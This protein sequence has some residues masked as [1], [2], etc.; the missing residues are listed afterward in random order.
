MKT[1]LLLLLA[2]CASAPQKQIA[3]DAITTLPTVLVDEAP[4]F[5]AK[6]SLKWPHE[7][8]RVASCVVRHPGFLAEVAAHP[9]Y[10]YTDKTPMEVAES[11]RTMHPVL[12]RT[13]KTANPWSKAIA[14]RA[15]KEPQSIYFN[16]RK[17]PRDMA[18]NA[19]TSTHEALHCLGFGHGDNDIT[20][21]T[22]QKKL[23]APYG[24]GAIAEKYVKDCL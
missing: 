1:L 2:S 20:K 16:T 5:T 15:P 7:V 23:S 13:Y 14:Y 11:F 21:N 6:S 9:G 10:T 19:N 17:Q 4:I 8:A 3:P 24:V 12:I 18:S 22:A